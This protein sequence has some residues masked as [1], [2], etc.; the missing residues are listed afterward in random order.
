[1]ENF[2]HCK[3]FLG[4]G[5][6]ERMG[7]ARKGIWHGVVFRQTRSEAEIDKRSLPAGRGHRVNLQ[8][9]KMG[10]TTFALLAPCSLRPCASVGLAH[11][12]AAER[13]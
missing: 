6:E 1:M 3:F 12:S 10:G 2:A 9:E 5:I 8:N 7:Q 4:G 11:I 13:R